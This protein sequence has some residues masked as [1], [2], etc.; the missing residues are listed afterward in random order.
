LPAALEVALLLKEV[1]LVPCE[2]METRE[3]ATSG[4][5][6]LAPGHLAVSL[7]T[8][9][10][11]L[12]GEAEE[13]CR[14]Q[15]ATVLALPAAPADPRLAVLSTFPAAVALATELAVRAGLDP[16]EPAWRDAYLATARA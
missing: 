14:A 15:G 4:M 13:I 16:D 8:E 2:G 3:G 7:P 5:Y 6:A 12:V 10:D 11:P 9:E 1:P